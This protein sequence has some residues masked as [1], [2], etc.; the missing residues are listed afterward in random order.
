MRVCSDCGKENVAHLPRKIKGFGLCPHQY[1]DIIAGLKD[2]IR[3]MNQKAYQQM[4]I[5]VRNRNETINQRNQQIKD[6]KFRL[7]ERQ[8]KGE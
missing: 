8:A 3:T 5:A 1:E 7:N 2:Q 6:L 4:A